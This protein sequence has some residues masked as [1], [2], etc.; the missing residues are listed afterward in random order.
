M[1]K[2]LLFLP[3]L[4]AIVWWWLHSPNI[5]TTRNVEPPKANEFAAS[6][7]IVET[8]ALSQKTIAP[9]T[10]QPIRTSEEFGPADSNWKSLLKRQFFIRSR[11]GQ[12]FGRMK[13]EI[14]SKYN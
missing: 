10:N 14:I 3:I 4:G 12:I 9:S 1:R 13:V 6:S 2:T 7:E 11:G 8:K 5:Q